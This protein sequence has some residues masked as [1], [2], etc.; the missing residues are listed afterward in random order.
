MLGR[1]REVAGEMTD[2]G[3]P[4]DGEVE[5]DE[6]YLAGK[7]KD[8]HAQQRT[9]RRGPVGLRASKSLSVCANAPA[10]SRQMR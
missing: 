3:G 9:G 7:D 4:M 10:G 8:K 5:V 2:H 1:L 6:T